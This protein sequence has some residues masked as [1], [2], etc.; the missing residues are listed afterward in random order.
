MDSEG[1]FDVRFF[2]LELRRR[3]G[4]ND[5]HLNNRR[6]THPWLSLKEAEGLKRRG[7]EGRKE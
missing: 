3:G 1:Q 2:G 7:S 4:R 5:T 6:Y